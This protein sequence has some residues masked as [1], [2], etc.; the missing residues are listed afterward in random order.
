MIRVRRSFKAA[1]IIIAGSLLGCDQND[2]PDSYVYRQHMRD[3]VVKISDYARTKSASFV[4]IPQNGLDLVAQD[5]DGEAPGNLAPAEAYLAAIDGVG[6]ED[7][8]YGYDA[9]D[10]PTPEDVTN[11]FLDLLALAE[12][13]GVQALVTDYCSTRERMDDSYASNGQHGF[14]SFAADHRELDNIPAHPAVPH[15]DNAE[16]VSTLA[17]ARNFLYLINPS[18]FGSRQAYMD[19]LA[20]ARHDIVLIDF[21][22]DNSPVTP[23]EVARLKQK[24]QGGSRL[25]IAYMSIGEAEDYRYYWRSNWKPGEPAW[26]EAVN[27]DWPGNFVV[28]YWDPEWQAIIYGSPD[29][30]LDRIL[31]AGFDGVYLDIIDAF[32]YFESME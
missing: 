26:I 6:R 1:A 22:H 13:S 21:F 12:A 5:P 29:A 14:I 18:A 9:D 3:F 19:A 10:E 16:T 15:G 7:L 27:P 20:A 30:Y 28:Q 24:P 25:V 11:G 8:F 4:V 31:A 17:Q 2:A 23:E 32:E